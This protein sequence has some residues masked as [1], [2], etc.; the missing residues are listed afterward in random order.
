MV[1]YSIINDRN[2][3]QLKDAPSIADISHF[4]STKLDQ[5]KDKIDQY[6][7]SRWNGYSLMRLNVPNGSN[8]LLHYHARFL[9][10]VT[11]ID[12]LLETEVIQND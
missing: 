3:N 8:E 6:P 12:Q 2:L 9:I 1:R 5:I 11:P 4:T 10:D 7:V